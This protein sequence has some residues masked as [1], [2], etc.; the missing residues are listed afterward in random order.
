MSEETLKIQANHLIRRIP[1]EGVIALLGGI[2]ATS[3]AAAAAGKTLG[4]V[5]GGLVA[6]TLIVPPLAAFQSAWRARGVIMVSGV[7]GVSVVWLS[8]IGSNGATI[9][10]W[11]ELTGILAG[12]V[13]VLASVT[14]LLTA[15]RFS[16]VLAA[17]V[18]VVM[19]LAWL[20][21]P[22]WLSGA[23][24]N[25][26]VQP[27]ISKLVPLNPP[28]VANGILTFTAPWTEQSIAYGLTLLDQDVPMRLPTTAL[29]CI[30]L[31]FASAIIISLFARKIYRV[32]A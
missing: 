10:Q 8:L 22:I 24:S 4:E 17:A 14:S 3:L 18:A 20:S 2:L 15:I 9:G 25:P 30:A 27:L 32:S 29:P 7:V 28:L 12:M 23:M 5:L 1:P 31:E 6:A 21:W 11:I 26:L 16:P 19:G 13:F